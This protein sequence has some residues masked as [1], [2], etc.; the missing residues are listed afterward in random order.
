M[1]AARRGAVFKQLW[2]IAVLVAAAATSACE[3]ILDLRSPQLEERDA[4]SDAPVDSTPKAC[5]PAECPF[6]CD[7]D[8]N[9]CR[10]GKLWV[11]KTANAF[12]G[13]AFGGA[14]MPPNVRG[15]A[16]A[17]CLATFAALYADRKC[18]PTRMRAVL[19]V[20]STDSIALMATRFSIPTGVPVHRI[21][22]DVLVANN[23]NDLTDPT[24]PLRAPATTAT[25]D[26]DGT[27]W[28]GANTAAT[29]ANW[30]SAALADSGTRG[31]TTRTSATWLSQD[32]FR[33]DRSA[34]L[35]C[36]CW[37]GGE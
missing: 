10:P 3:Q 36:V 18:N 35:L 15:G 16:D 6:G 13:N 22:D 33:C 20:N 25:N 28:S 26:A 24:K 30:T 4:G 37:T 9:A 19:H 32:T 34:S 17:K 5:Q 14:D 7:A 8:A 2:L 31:Y 21:N 27:V 1:E 11:F 29:C 12:L 23:W